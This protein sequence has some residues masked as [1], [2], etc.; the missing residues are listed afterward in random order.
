M[1]APSPSSSRTEG[2]PVIRRHHTSETDLGAPLIPLLG[3]TGQCLAPR[4]YVGLQF[5]PTHESVAVIRRRFR[6][7]RI[8]TTGDWDSGSVAFTVSVGSNATGSTASWNSRAL[9]PACSC[10][11]SLSASGQLVAQTPPSSVS[12]LNRGCDDAPHGAHRKRDNLAYP[13]FVARSSI[14]LWYSLFDSLVRS[15]LIEELNMF[16]DHPMQVSVS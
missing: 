10:P 6:Q 8:F 12:R 7:V 2:D 13:R 9:L 5:M 14:P 16:F 1:A 15:S 11:F 4:R 3:L